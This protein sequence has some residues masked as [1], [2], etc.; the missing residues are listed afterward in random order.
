M[1]K[2]SLKEFEDLRVWS[3][4]KTGMCF[5]VSLAAAPLSCT[6]RACHKLH[7]VVAMSSLLFLL[8]SPSFLPDSCHNFLTMRPLA[9]PATALRAINLRQGGGVWRARSARY[10]LRFYTCSRPDSQ[11]LA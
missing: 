10:R 2:R 6:H 5:F 7:G 8:Q 9:S 3:L 1:G 4:L 11:T